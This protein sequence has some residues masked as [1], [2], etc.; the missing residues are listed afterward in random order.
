MPEGEGLHN[1]LTP[2]GCNGSGRVVAP[3]H[4]QRLAPK[5]RDRQAAVISQG[6]WA[7]QKLSGGSILDLS[8]LQDPSTLGYLLI[9]GLYSKPISCC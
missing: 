8:K 2:G 6:I 1:S 7:S 3:P 4:C 9:F 5:G